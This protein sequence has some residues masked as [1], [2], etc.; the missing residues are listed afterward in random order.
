MN[1]PHTHNQSIHKWKIFGCFLKAVI[2]FFG[3][4]SNAIDFYLSIDIHACI[5]A[6]YVIITHTHTHTC[7]RKSN[8]Y[9]SQHFER[10]KKNKIN[11]PMRQ[12]LL[13]DKNG[14]HCCC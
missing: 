4:N 13:S 5:H 3:D 11:I 10:G 8:I 12:F 7:M 1:I 9:Q 14:S 2:F 6:Y